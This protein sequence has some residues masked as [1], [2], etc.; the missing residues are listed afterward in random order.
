MRFRPISIISLLICGLFPLSNAEDPSGE[1]ADPGSFYGFWQ[2]DEPA[3]DSCVVIIKRGGRLSR[4]WSGIASSSIQK[5]QWSMEEGTLSAQWESGQIEQ[6]RKLGENAMER[7]SYAPGQS[8]I[9][10]P[11]SKVRG[12]RLD[13]R[14]PGSLT[15]ETDQ[16]EVTPSEEPAALSSV[17][18]EQV[19][20]SDPEKFAE[21]AGFWKLS[22]SSGMLGLGR[23]E[24]YFYLHLTRSGE[25]SVALRDWKGDN[26]LKGKWVPVDGEARIIWPGNYKDRL[27][28]NAD[29]G[30]TL[31]SFGRKR[32]FDRKPQESTKAERVPE[33]EAARYFKAGDFSRLTVTDIRGTWRPATDGSSR[34]YISVEGWGNAYRYPA[35]DGLGGT[36]P[37]KWRLLSDRVVITWVDG[38]KDVIRIAFPDFVLDSFAPGQA[39]TEA[40]FRSLTVNRSQE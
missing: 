4:F 25:A 18:Q 1:T 38:Y 26:A 22:Q 20:E 5:G 13:S 17:P 31:A 32:D 28:R 24:P 33:S 10:E 30:Y 11:S 34:E 35:R 36:D 23:G 3:G 19:T 40:P 6:Y 14:L 7:L 9:A 21:F 29:D 8:L 37:G 39:L 12:V 15:V 16:D 2:F 27:S